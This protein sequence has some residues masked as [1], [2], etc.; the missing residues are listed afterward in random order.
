LP[1]QF[2]VDFEV[3]LSLSIAKVLQNHPMQ[4]KNFSGNA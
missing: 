1:C 3:F 2:L 4:V